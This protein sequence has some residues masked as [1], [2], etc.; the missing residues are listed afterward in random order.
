MKSLK[1]SS[2]NG[3]LT[4]VMQKFKIISDALASIYTVDELL[5]SHSIGDIDINLIPTD[6]F[7][8]IEQILVD[9]DVQNYSFSIQD[10]M[11][12]DVIQRALLEHGLNFSDYAISE[13][14]SI[15]AYEAFCVSVYLAKSTQNGVIHEQFI[16]DKLMSVD[17]IRPLVLAK[18][19][20]KDEKRFIDAMFY[21]NSYG[22]FN[23]VQKSFKMK[24][25]VDRAL[26]G[27]ISKKFNDY[28]HSFMYN[29]MFM[30]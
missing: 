20:V 26:F 24:I 27:T 15:D 8:A 23:F 25:N 4:N 29:K 11:L 9:L 16:I 1:T 6:R 2:S 17:N 3:I 13:N 10:L 5:F 12:F 28:A 19:F 7:P 30:N 22:L 14:I 21:A 18:M